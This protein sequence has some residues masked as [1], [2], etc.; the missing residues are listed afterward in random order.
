MLAIAKANR[1]YENISYNLA[2][3]YDIRTEQKYEGLFEGFIWSHIKLEKIN[4]FLDNTR[5]LLEKG[6]SIGFIDS[7]IVANTNHDEKKTVKTDT[8][9]NTYQLRK[10]KNGTKHLIVKNYPTKEFVYE[11]LMNISEEIEIEQL[12][13]YWIASCKLKK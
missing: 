1:S 4:S 12:H 13:H 7:N 6:A 9:G 11:K 3:M 5:N 10:L 8:Y 2:N